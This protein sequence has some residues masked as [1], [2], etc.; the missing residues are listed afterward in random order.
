MIGKILGLHH[1]FFA[2]KARRVGVVAFCAAWGALE[3]MLGSTGWAAL[4]FGLAAVSGYEFFITF[5]PANYRR[6]D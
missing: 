6:K 1:P 4:A 3:L 2:P 5:D